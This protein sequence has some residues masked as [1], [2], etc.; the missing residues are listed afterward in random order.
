LHLPAGFE[1]SLGQRDGGQDRA[2]AAAPVEADFL[3][4]EAPF[5]L[6]V[7]GETEKVFSFA[8]PLRTRGAKVKTKNGVS[9]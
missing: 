4:P 8:K 5:R 2:L 6:Q 9:R 7:L 1:E 3:H